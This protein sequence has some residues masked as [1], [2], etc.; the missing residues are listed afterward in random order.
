MTAGCAD[1]HVHTDNSD[2]TQR[3]D[4]LLASARAK[5]LTTLAVTDHAAIPRELQDRHSVIGGVEV[6]A[7][8]EIKVQF[9]N[10]RGELL[11]LAVDPTNAAL[12]RLLLDRQE[13]RRDR[14]V[15][16][17]RCCEKQ[18]GVSL[19]AEDLDPTGHAASLGRP[20]LAR[21]LVRRGLVASE[22]EAFERYLG[23][24]KPCHVPLS[25]PSHRSVTRTLLDA[26]GVVSIAHPCLME[27]ANWGTLLDELRDGG[28]SAM[29]VF[30]PYGRAHSRL[31]IT[32]E[33]ACRLATSRGLLLTGGS[34]HHGP[35]SARDTLGSVC[36]PEEH[37]AALRR[38]CGVP[39]AT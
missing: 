15:E 31:H 30:Y 6:W 34:D 24:S 4:E 17:L 10:A 37:L 20:H 23:R 18:F 32:P 12:I 5:G 7:G 29:E 13:E 39:T 27:V 8:V 2:G 19:A 35:G 25:R 14:L 11:G 3:V 28:V 22:R 21:L 38:A 9:P 26:G 16:M 33:G 1:L 36:V